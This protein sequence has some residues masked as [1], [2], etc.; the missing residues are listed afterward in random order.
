VGSASGDSVSRNLAIAVRLGGAAAPVVNPSSFTV[1]Y[2]TVWKY[3]IATGK[4]V[5]G[6]SFATT[7]SNDNVIYGI[8][9]DN[10][11][12]NGLN[13]NS[14]LSIITLSS[15]SIPIDGTTINPMLPFG[16]NSGQVSSSGGGTFKADGIISVAGKL[17]ISISQQGT[18]TGSPPAGV[19]TEDNGTI[20]SSTDH[21]ANWSSYPPN[22]TTY[23]PS[24]MFS[25]R[26]FAA[27]NFIQYGQDYAGQPA[28]NSNQYVYATSNEGCWNNCSKLFLGRVLIADLPSLTGSTWQFYQGGDGSNPANWSTNWGTAAPLINSSRHIGNVVQAQYIKE[29]GVYFWIGWY[30]P[31]APTVATIDTT[32]TVWDFYAAPHPWGPWTLFGSKTW[33]SSPGAGLYSPNIITKSIAV[34]GNTLSANIATAGDYNTWNNPSTGDYTLTIVPLS[35]TAQ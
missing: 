9:D 34:S 27:P 11:G 5:D 28:D 25:G 4:T 16:P 1:G 17:Y 14:N 19:V 31:N 30:Y 26:T 12:F 21:G 33:N 2:G 23:Y 22:T 3:N 13:T 35:V 32:T 18:Q 10:H 6:D 15:A 20:I 29:W 24:P 8:H 7:W